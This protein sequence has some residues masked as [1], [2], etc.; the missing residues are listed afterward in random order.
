MEECID[1]GPLGYNM[2]SLI[3]PIL[4]NEFYGDQKGL[5]EILWTWFYQFLNIFPL[6]LKV[7]FGRLHYSSI[8]PNCIL[9]VIY[10]LKHSQMGSCL[11]HLDVNSITIYNFK[12]IH[13]RNITYWIS[14]STHVQFQMR[15]LVGIGFSIL[16]F[17]LI[18]CK[19]GDWMNLYR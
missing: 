14:A 5:F 6:T 17:T 9:F 16:K 7:S 1:H 4:A 15:H 2:P 19:V 18:F 3:V 11:I 10:K 12:I 13:I 8:S